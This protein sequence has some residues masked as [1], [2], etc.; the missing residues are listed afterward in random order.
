ML[1]G[2]RLLKVQSGMRR[3]S[4]GWGRSWG[5]RRT[6]KELAGWS[7]C[8]GAPSRTPATGCCESAFKI[9]DQITCML[10]MSSPLSQKIVD[11]FTF[12]ISF[13]C[14]WGDHGFLQNISLALQPAQW[15][16]RKASLSS[17]TNICLQ[18]CARPN[19]KDQKRRLDWTENLKLWNCLPMM[20]ANVGP[21]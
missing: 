11:N 8:Q 5:E 12:L 7:R 1:S 9:I 21:T 18:T 17:R 16:M 3:P 4:S 2:R 14:N 15:W 10:S 19:S 6:C 13:S 20:H